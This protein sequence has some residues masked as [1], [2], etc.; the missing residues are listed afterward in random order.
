MPGD[1]VLVMVLCDTGLNYWNSGS[2][3]NWLERADQL[4]LDPVMETMLGR[5]ARSP[6]WCIFGDADAFRSDPPPAPRRA[7]GDGWLNGTL[8]Q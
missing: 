4:R 2:G 3:P 6:T 1:A 8:P 5:Q 7:Q